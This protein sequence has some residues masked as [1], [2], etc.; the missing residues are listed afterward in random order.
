MPFFEGEAKD[1]RREFLYWN[2]DG[3]LVAIRINDWKVV[4]KE[5]EHEGMYCKGISRIC[6]CRN[7]LSSALIHSSAAMS[8]SFTTSGW[9]IAPSSR[10]RRK[11]SSQIGWEFPIRQKPA[12]FNL[13]SVMEKLSPTKRPGE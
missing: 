6:V 12:S 7:C 11:R 3:E 5:Q 1:P 13:N 9:P 8:R 4:F 2:D 10:F